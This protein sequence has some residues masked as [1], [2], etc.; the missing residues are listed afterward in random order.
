MSRE[1][2]RNKEREACTA[3]LRVPTSDVRYNIDAVRLSG[4]IMSRHCLLG[5]TRKVPDDNDNRLPKVYLNAKG[6][7]LPINNDGNE[8]RA[9]SESSPPKMKQR[10]KPN[11]CW[12]RR[13]AGSTR[14]A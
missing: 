14:T 12:P 10:K 9:E 5:P 4:P 13:A 11:S 7:G 3:S 2:R 6:A 1:E 8:P